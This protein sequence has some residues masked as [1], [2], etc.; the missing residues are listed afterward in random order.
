MSDTKNRTLENQ[1]KLFLSI[2]MCRKKVRERFN[3]F[4]SSNNLPVTFDQWLILQEINEVKGINQKTIAKNLAKEVAAVSRIIN[5]LEKKGLITR[6]SNSQNLREFKTYL[7]PNGIEILN[8][9]SSFEKETYNNLFSG[10][11]EQELYLVNNV[12]NRIFN[13]P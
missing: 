5:K 11:Y 8:K 9:A 13:N 12:L 10:V 7:A 6:T 2:Q 1:K 4:F 3:S